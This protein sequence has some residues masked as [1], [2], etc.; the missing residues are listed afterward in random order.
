MQII[1]VCA[2][3]APRAH[4]ALLPPAFAA[5]DLGPVIL[6]LPYPRSWPSTSRHPSL[7]AEA[8]SGGNLARRGVKVVKEGNQTDFSFSVRDPGHGR[9]CPQFSYMYTMLI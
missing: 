9:T 6:T 2:V 5:S 4:P 8:D 3:S 1:A 7:A